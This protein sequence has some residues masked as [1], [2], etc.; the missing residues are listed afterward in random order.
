MQNSIILQNLNQEQ[1]TDLIDDRLTM[2]F[3]QL[4]V[5]LNGKSNFDELL[6]R[7]ETCKFLSVNS[8]TLWAWTKKGKVTSY[9]IGSRRY[10]KTS[11][12]LQSLIQVI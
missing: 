3:E 10:Y 2:Q 8:S 6:T 11:E 1:L 4:K 9:A 12:L 7:E 5:D